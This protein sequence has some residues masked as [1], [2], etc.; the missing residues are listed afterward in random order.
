MLYRPVTCTVTT[1]KPLPPSSPM[2]TSHHYRQLILQL[3]HGLKRG[4][5]RRPSIAAPTAGSPQQ[6][7]RPPLQR[8]LYAV[9]SDFSS[10][11]SGS[12]SGG[13]SA[14]GSGNGSQ[15]GNRNGRPSSSS[16]SSTASH[17][18][19]FNQYTKF[20]Q[21]ERAASNVEMSRKVDY[22]RDEVARRLCERLL[23]RREI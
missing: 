6:G 10:N 16:S 15:S 2:S 8:R 21:K 20:L 9:H 3:P 13:H 19:V 5:S 1:Q 12:S 7:C 22:L 14:S 23:V 18:Q 17:L 4:S 11:K